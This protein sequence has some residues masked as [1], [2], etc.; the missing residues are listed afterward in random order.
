LITDQHHQQHQQQQQQQPSKRQRTNQQ[1]RAA[2]QQAAAE[3][4]GCRQQ[5]VPTDQPP[6]DAT[7]QLQLK[8]QPRGKKIQQLQKQKL[9]EGPAAAAAAAAGDITKIAATTAAEAE[10]CDETRRAIETAV[11]DIQEQLDMASGH[12][13]ARYE[14]LDDLQAAA[15]TGLDSTEL[16]ALQQVLAWLQQRQTWH[17]QLSMQGWQLLRMQQQQQQQV[18]AAGVLVATWLD[19]ASCCC[20]CWWPAASSCKLAVLLLI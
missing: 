8:Q 18:A 11:L 16:Q 17:M 6:L 2:Q 3:A 19:C 20:S 5:D 9:Q 12:C 15:N 10:C 1:Q 14:F 13:Y 4:T 7:A